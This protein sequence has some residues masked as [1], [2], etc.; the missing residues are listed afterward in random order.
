LP[1]A[2]ATV[3][4]PIVYS[5]GGAEERKGFDGDAAAM[6]ASGGACESAKRGG[7][8]ALRRVAR[9]QRIVLHQFRKDQLRPTTQRRGNNSFE[10]PC[11]VA[12]FVVNSEPHTGARPSVRLGV[13]PELTRCVHRKFIIPAS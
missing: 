9:L 5:C 3:E 11:G 13:G 4:A 7:G 2:V 6:F 12:V 8:G 10:S 1:H